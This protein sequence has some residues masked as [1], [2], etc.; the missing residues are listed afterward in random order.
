MAGAKKKEPKRTGTFA[1]AIRR[2]IAHHKAVAHV[3]FRGVRVKTDEYGQLYVNARIVLQDR[4][5]ARQSG[6]D[7][8]HSILE[9]IRSLSDRPIGRINVVITNIALPADKRKAEGVTP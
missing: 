9:T 7:V 6:Y 4:V 1:R 5:N 2:A 8:Q 3:T